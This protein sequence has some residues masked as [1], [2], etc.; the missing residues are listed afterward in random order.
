VKASDVIGRQI[1]VREGGSVIGKI[2]DLVVDPSGREVI[3]IVL[4]DGM[5]S[6]SRVAPWKAVQAFGPDSVVIDMAKSVVKASALPEIKAVLDSKNRI[7]GLRL[8]TTK[9]RELGKISDFLFDES[10]GDLVGYEL[11]SR[12]FSDAFDG[13]P[14]LPTP[15]WIELGKDVA[16]VDPDVESTVSPTGGIHTALLRG[17][18]PPEPP[19]PAADVEASTDAPSGTVTGPETGP[20]TG[21][22]IG[23]GPGPGVV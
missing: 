17:A 7:K 1:T 20:V 14:F 15:Q 23:P 22:E 19:R 21:S 9:G 12:L 5:F 8:T 11:S 13:T 6:G 16:F 4:A 3:G 18:T 10:T 2:R